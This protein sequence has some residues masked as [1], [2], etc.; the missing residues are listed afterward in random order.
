MKPPWNEFLDWRSD[1]QRGFGF[2][3]VSISTVVLFFFILIVMVFYKRCKTQQ[4]CGA[5]SFWSSSANTSHRER[6]TAAEHRKVTD[7][8]FFF[9]KSDGCWGFFI[10][11]RYSSFTLPWCPG[12]WSRVTHTDKEKIYFKTVLFN[13]SQMLL[14]SPHSSQWVGVQ[15][16]VT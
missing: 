5:L 8:Y 2:S 4:L 6:E 11:S 9:F 15:V 3:K 16:S 13:I 10:Q 12:T 7:L 14:F 1:W